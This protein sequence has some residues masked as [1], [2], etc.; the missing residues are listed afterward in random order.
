[1]LGGGK[2]TNVLTMPALLYILRF[3]SAVGRSYITLL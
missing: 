3:L 1:M 2:E